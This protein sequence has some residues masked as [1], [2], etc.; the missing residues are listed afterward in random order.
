MP[1][2]TAAGSSSDLVE[3]VSPG[4]TARIVDTDIT[5]GIQIHSHDAARDDEVK[6]ELKEDIAQVKKE[7]SYIKNNVAEL[8]GSMN[9]LIGIIQSCKE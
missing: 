5:G 9:M 2:Q 1:W 3:Y 7:V 6:K 4:S 8:K